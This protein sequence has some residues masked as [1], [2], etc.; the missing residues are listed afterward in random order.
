[1]ATPTV[2]ILGCPVCDGE[3]RHAFSKGTYDLGRCTSCRSLV[4]HNPPADTGALYDDSYFNGGTTGHGYGSY[5][6][7][8]EVTRETLEHCLD[9]I[10]D[11]APRG[12]LYD[13]GA[14]TGYFLTCARERG[15]VVSG[16]DISA[17][18][19]REAANKGV[20]VHVGTT[21][22]SIPDHSHDVITAFDVLEHVPDPKVILTE[23]DR[24]LKTEGVFMAST[25]NAT[26]ALARLLGKYWTLIVPPEHLV[27]MSEKGMRMLLSRYGYEVQWVGTIGK[28]FTLPYI[29]QIASLW[30]QLPFLARVGEW[31][32]P[33]VLGRI[34]IPLNLGDTLFFLAIKRS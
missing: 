15:Y 30:L 13:V 33:R 2:S 16:V 5:D 26:S 1:M 9:R 25:P 28:R 7:E 27:L 19:A 20:T 8:K 32:R 11:Y 4:V 14:A 3:T 34:A 17:A 18:A 21:V 12:S 22:P 6:R 10:A 24:L 29:L 31:L 23:I